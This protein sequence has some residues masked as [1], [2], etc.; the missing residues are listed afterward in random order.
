MGMPNERN[1]QVSKQTPIFPPSVLPVRSG[2]YA[3]QNIDPEDGLP[4]DGWAYSWF[5]LTDCVWGCSAPTPE[6]AFANP[7]Y[8]FAWQTKQW[9]GLTQEAKS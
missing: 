9:R 7:D 3:T 4:K 2:V 1:H 5:D 8:E 6:E